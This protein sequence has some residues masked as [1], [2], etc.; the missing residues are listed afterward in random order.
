MDTDLQVDHPPGT[1]VVRETGRGKFQQEVISGAH[2]LL[3]DEP[4]NVGGLDSGPAPYELLLGALGAC[5]AMTVRL[6]ADRKQFP[7]RQ[8]QVRL[9]HKR[10]YAE[11]CAE[12]GTESGMIDRIE[13]AITLEGNL[14]DEQ[15]RRLIEISEKCPV[16]RTLTSEIDSHGQDPKR[17]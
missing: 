11:D 2:R 7:L 5:K 6:H 8:V 14:N 15:R 1:V 10:V 4:K 3:A 13:C 16:H 17:T 9:L 12:C